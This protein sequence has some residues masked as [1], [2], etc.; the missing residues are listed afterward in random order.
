MSFR[1]SATASRKPATSTTTVALNKHMRSGSCRAAKTIRQLT[2][3]SHYRPDLTNYAIARY[4][5]LN[6]SKK[7][8]T[9]I[10]KQNKRKLA[11]KKTV[12]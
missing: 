2:Q 1:A 12:A 4:H 3:N 6:K 10:N 7:V 9:R 11:A 5:A 8:N